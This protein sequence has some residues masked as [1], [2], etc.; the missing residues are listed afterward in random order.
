MEDVASLLSRHFSQEDVVQ[1]TDLVNV[2]FD[3]DLE[4][5]KSAESEPEFQ[6]SGGSLLHFRKKHLR[7][8]ILTNNH[9]QNKQ[10]QSCFK[11]PANRI[12]LTVQ[13]KKTRLGTILAID[14]KLALSIRQQQPIERARSLEGTKFVLYKI[15]NQK[16]DVVAQLNEQDAFFKDFKLD[17]TGSYVKEIP[18][19][20]AIITTRFPF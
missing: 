6:P 3:H 18:I 12:I 11:M 8:F 15:K 16:G 1:V 13:S 20:G 4:K 17:G 9:Y 19:S 2:L 14:I 10:K 5:R 7:Y